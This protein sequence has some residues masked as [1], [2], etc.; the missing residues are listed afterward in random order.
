MKQI[1][2]LVVEDR[3]DWQ[4]IVCSTLSEAGYTPHAVASYAE[5]VDLLERQSVAL[6]LVDPVLDSRNRFNRDGLSVIQSI[7][8]RQPHIPIVII[9]GS[10]T[11]D[12]QASLNALTIE[13]PV[14]LKESW[15][16]T[17]FTALV[18][19]LVEPREQ[20]AQVQ[21][22]STA[23]SPSVASY[24]SP[25]A[26]DQTAAGSPRVLV[27]ENRADWQHIVC[28][29]L[30]TAGCFWR[31][32]STAQEALREL[33]QENF[34]LVILDLKLQAQD[35]PLTSSEG[36]LLLDYLVE[37]H[38]TTSVVILSGKAHPGDVA[39]LLTRYPIIGFIE[40]QRF[41]PQDI[42]RAIEQATRAP[43][44][45]IQ[46]FGQFRIWRDG[47]A[48]TTWERPQ[49]ESIVKML[50]VRRA[51]GERSMAADQIITLLWPDDDEVSGRKKLL[52]LISNARRTLEPDI[53]PRDS[54]YIVRSGNG[55]FFDLGQSIHWDVLQFR[56]HVQQGC[57]LAQQ[58]QWEE[59]IAELERAD[60]LYSGDFLAED[61][62]TDWTMDLRRELVNDFCTALCTLAECATHLQRYP[63]AIEACEAVLRKDPLREG[64]YRQ[65]MHLHMLRGDKGQ[66]L[67]IYR[68]C[69]VLF[70]ELFGESPSPLTRRLHQEIMEG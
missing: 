42:H 60:K 66:A 65:L 12:M 67:K 22:K 35:V 17:A 40:K 23:T 16:P 2:I 55:Y 6:A 19:S 18:R 52:P 62:Y 20:P 38:P 3:T 47:Q 54:H 46:S 68:D 5:A 13:S 41:N 43:L 21:P 15:N 11:H 63:Q 45:R 37:S 59:A 36:W 1:H 56:E 28:G 31:A 10:F 58:E 27:V 14:I 57:M 30:D 49:A 51:Q 33:E 9:T 7:R 61:C 8:N 64:V 48:I 34:H 24:P 32:S 44:L 26:A 70:E 53:E 69:S 29:V 4:T 50:L 39:D 25:P